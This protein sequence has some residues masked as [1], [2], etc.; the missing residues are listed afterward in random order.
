[1]KPTRQVLV[2][3]SAVWAAIGALVA[4]SQ[5]PQ[6]NPDAR[7]LVATA[8]V[9]FPAAAAGAALALHRGALR[10]AGALLVLSVATPTY[11]AYPLNLPALVVGAGLLAAPGAFVSPTTPSPTGRRARRFS[12]EG[13]PARSQP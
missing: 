10:W 3:G 7:W 4:L 9:A 5:V 12:P 11:M 1:M 6:A 13:G 2:I 8:S